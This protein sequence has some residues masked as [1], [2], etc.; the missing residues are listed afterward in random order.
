MT[1]ILI[2][3]FTRIA[4]A[5]GLSL[6]LAMGALTA[7]AAP[8]RADNADAARLLG[9]IIA[10]YAL[11]RALESSQSHARPRHDPPRHRPT[12]VAPARCFIEGRDSNGPYR[13]YVRRCMQRNADHV[14]FL[15]D[16]CL[17]RVHTARGDRM[18][19]GGRCLARNGW[20]REAGV[21]H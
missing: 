21:R 2:A 15:P 6:A 10:L 11:G 1:R 9:G 12:L 20:V 19:Y 8:A 13:G 16:N 4:T 7:S 3:R 5:A 17:R 18:I 14:R